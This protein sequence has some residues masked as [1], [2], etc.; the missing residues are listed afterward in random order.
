L[1]TKTSPDGRR[2]TYAYRTDNLISS[3][4]DRKSQTTS[5]TYDAAKRLTQETAAGLITSYIYS[6]RNQLTSTTNPSGTVS[7]VYDGAARLT[8]ETNSGQTIHYTYSSDWFY[9]YDAAGRLVRAD[10]GQ[11]NFAYTYDPL[12]NILD[13]DRTHD[14]A[15]RLLADNDYTFTYRSFFVAAGEVLPQFFTDGIFIGFRWQDAV[16]QEPHCFSSR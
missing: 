7:A 2:Q 4:T 1:F 3:T 9:Q 10:H 12:G 13:N 11:D 15:N 6:A 14:I 5:Y 8:Q 16:T